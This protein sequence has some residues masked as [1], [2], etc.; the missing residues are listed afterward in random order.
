MMKRQMIATGCA[1][2]HIGCWIQVREIEET[3]QE[4]QSV[5]ISKV[6]ANNIDHVL[7]MFANRIRYLLEAQNFLPA[8]SALS[9]VLPIAN[10]ISRSDTFSNI[11]ALSKK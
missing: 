4:T 9:V 3:N 7:C 11:F 8:F 5:L 2:M 6:N 1:A 10:L